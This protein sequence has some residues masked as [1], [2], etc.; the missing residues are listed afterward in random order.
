MLL[1]ADHLTAFGF[2]GHS[3]SRPLCVCRSAGR[4]QP[5]SEGDLWQRG[6]STL[7]MMWES[8]TA[9]TLLSS[10]SP[11]VTQS[12]ES[13]TRTRQSSWLYFAHVFFMKLLTH[14][15]QLVPSRGMTFLSPTQNQ[16]IQESPNPITVIKGYL[17][18]CHA[19]KLYFFNWNFYFYL[20]LLGPVFF[21][22][23][24][25]LPILTSD[26]LSLF[27][28]LQRCTLF[29]LLIYYHVQ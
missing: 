21:I 26:F 2:L 5:E 13:D 19:E 29:S 23:P 4:L 20:T 8:H 7:Q 27:Y 15:N 14:L 10:N 17:S 12:K 3:R 18:L 16:N 22:L 25:I 28:I 11:S 6:L 9:D 1:L 24:S